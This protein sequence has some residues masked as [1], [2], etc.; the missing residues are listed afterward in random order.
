MR[1]NA[2]VKCGPDG[3]ICGR[4]VVGRGRCSSYYRRLRAGKSLGSPVRSY[5]R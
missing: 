3:E 1:V 5:L 2:K 4:K